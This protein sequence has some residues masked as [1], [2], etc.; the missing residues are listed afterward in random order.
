MFK[1]RH[2]DQVEDPSDPSYLNYQELSRPARGRLK[3][4]FE[5]A[6]AC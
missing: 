4:G 6:R 2:L 1:E 5:T 3:Q